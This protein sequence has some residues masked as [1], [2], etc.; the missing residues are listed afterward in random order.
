MGQHQHPSFDTFEPEFPL[1]ITPQPFV[2]KQSTMKEAEHSV[3][4]MTRM[5]SKKAH[6]IAKKAIKIHTSSERGLP[7]KIEKRRCKKAL[8]L[9]AMNDGYDSSDSDSKW[10]SYSG[11]I[12]YSPSASSFSL[13]SYGS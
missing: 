3:K 10:S 7:L 11:S 13:S 5:P 4:K 12:S 6:K 2:Q 8:D 9:G 1:K